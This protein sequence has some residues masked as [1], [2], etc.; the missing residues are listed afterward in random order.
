MSENV[1]STVLVLTD[2]PGVYGKDLYR[3]DLPPVFV[4]DIESLIAHL[5]NVDVAGL[6]LE[7]PKVMKAT[8]RE[9]DRLFSYAGSFPV[10]RT[11][12]DKRHGFVNYLDPRDS[13]FTN[14]DAAIGKRS[15]SHQRKTVNLACAFSHEDDP[16]MAAPKEAAIL[17]IS[18]GG[19]F[20][21]TNALSKDEHF[22]HLSIPQLNCT[23]PIFSSIRWTRTDSKNASLCGM[24][25]MF[26][27]ISDEQMQAIEAYKPL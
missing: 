11:K 9:R 3:N 26:I 6:V 5:K 10:M 19:C 17:D 20:I 8:R 15:R 7:V 24:G 25:V 21:N 1:R 16:S 18:T 14:L 13:F 12:A 22:L 2:T 23:R 4:Q 27:D